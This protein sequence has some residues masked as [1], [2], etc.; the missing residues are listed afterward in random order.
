[1]K[2]RSA[3]RRPRAVAAAAGLALLALG[4]V[5]CRPVPAQPLSP[6]LHEAVSPVAAAPGAAIAGEL[7]EVRAAPVLQDCAGARWRA[8][9]GNRFFEVTFKLAKGTYGPVGSKPAAPR[10]DDNRKSV[11]PDLLRVCRPDLFFVDFPRIT[12]VGEGDDDPALRTPGPEF[13]TALARGLA[14]WVHAADRHTWLFARPEDVRSDPLGTPPP[15][16]PFCGDRP[17]STEQLAVREAVLCQMVGALRNAATRA[18]RETLGDQGHNRAVGAMLKKIRVGRMCTFG[19]QGVQAQACDHRDVLE[20]H[21]QRMSVS[22]PRLGDSDAKVELALIDTGLVPQYSRTGLVAREV[23]A[24]SAFKGERVHEHGT[25]M[26]LL[27]RQ[28]APDRRLTLSSYRIFDQYGKS[29]PNLLARALD[30]ALHPQCQANVALPPVRLPPRGRE[31]AP[32]PRRPAAARHPL[33]VNLSLGWPP[34][35]SQPRTLNGWRGTP[36]GGSVRWE[37]CSVREDAVGAPVDFLLQTAAAMDSSRERSV[38]VVAAAGNRPDPYGNG[39]V[40]SRFGA[41]F[42]ANNSGG[43]DAMNSKREPLWF[44]PAQYARERWPL[45]SA[46]LVVGAVDDRDME[47]VL[48]IPRAEPALVAPGQH[49]YTRATDR[50]GACAAGPFPSDACRD[51]PQEG[52]CPCPGLH[53]PSAITGTSAATAL[54]S[55]A[56]ARAQLMRLT[57]GQRPLSGQRL[58]RLLYLSGEPMARQ[59]GLG[60]PA[61]T[62]QWRPAVVGTRVRRLALAP[63]DRLLEQPARLDAAI[64][65][66]LTTQPLS[67]APGGAAPPSGWRPPD[68]VVWRPDYGAPRTGRRPPTGL[69][70]ARSLWEEVTASTPQAWQDFFS[71]AGLGPLPPEGPCPECCIWGSEALDHKKWTIK[72]VSME[73]NDPAAGGEYVSAMVVVQSPAGTWKY[74]L[75][76]AQ[77]IVGKTITHTVSKT[78][79]GTLKTSSASLVLESKAPAL[80]STATVTSVAPLRILPQ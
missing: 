30:H 73:L 23:D 26:A 70:P 33:V 8:G 3:L 16:A 19:P 25:H 54:V 18:Y 61:V 4:T 58:T 5:R 60:T 21:L 29:T 42:G 28:L 57:R 74:T 7:V 72:S 13:A 45:G 67:G 32:H 71:L 15:D 36:D 6:A 41:A 31:L 53:L 52:G 14:D 37:Q 35:L 27:A 46:P 77:L 43:L 66:P 17:Q 9:G 22:D 59:L 2:G 12:P 47:T 56:A 1:M 38:L 63:M 76:P 24:G 10:V 11:G 79:E 20:W 55:G 65:D 68:P 40:A 34:E 49:V 78:F 69:G 44:Y 80:G 48:S 75:D 50:P 39:R 64:P 62:A 51:D